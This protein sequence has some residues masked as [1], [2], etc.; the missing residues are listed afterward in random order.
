[1]NTPDTPGTSHGNGAA[2]GNDTAGDITAASG[3][4][5]AL[6]AGQSILG[7]LRGFTPSETVA[8]AERA[9]DLGITAV[10]VT[11]EVPEQLPSLA[12]AVAAGRE[13]GHLVGAGTVHTAE[14]VASVRD[15]GAAFTVAPGFDPAVAAGS[16]AA[17]LPHLP[18]VAT[19]TEVQAALRSGH[20]WL[21][22]FPAA[23]LGP[24]FISAL[25]GPFPKLNIVATGGMDAS[26]AADFLR[27]GADV[28]ALGSALA[29]PTQ[30]DRVQA[31]LASRTS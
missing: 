29:D 1:M 22:V 31:L 26:N 11:V 28:V 15:A 19:P 25:R 13:R 18:G 3:F 16:L 5:D 27:A 2:A 14:Q 4:F 23:S 8:R 20:R 17:G 7:I 9:W 24:G 10:E 30:L 6:F 12:A 21:K